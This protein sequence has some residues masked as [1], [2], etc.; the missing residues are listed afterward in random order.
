M[1][2]PTLDTPVEAVGPFVTTDLGGLLSRCPACRRHRPGSDF[3]RMSKVCRDCDGGAYDR[4]LA[5]RADE[6]E[7][8]RPETAA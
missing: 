7:A 2:N 5:A 8:R 3:L 4:A 6:L 1:I